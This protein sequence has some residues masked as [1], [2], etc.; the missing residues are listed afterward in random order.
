MSSKTLLKLSNK[1]CQFYSHT[2]TH[3]NLAK[4]VFI[5]QISSNLEEK[6]EKEK[7]AESK[8]FMFFSSER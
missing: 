6:N 5:S 4:Q 3:A 8:V 1:R 7:L 2:Y